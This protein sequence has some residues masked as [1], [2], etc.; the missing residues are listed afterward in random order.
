MQPLLYTFHD[1]VVHMC[2]FKCIVRF[3]VMDSIGRILLFFTSF[4]L[5]FTPQWS[6]SHLENGI[7]S[8]TYDFWVGETVCVNT[9]LP[10]G[11]RL[12]SGWLL[13]LIQ[14]TTGKVWFLKRCFCVCHRLSFIYLMAMS[15][16]LNMFL[17][18]FFKC[19]LPVIVLCAEVVIS[20]CRVQRGPLTQ[21]IRLVTHSQ[22]FSWMR[23]L[24]PRS[25]LS[26]NGG[27]EQPRWGPLLH[28]CNWMLLA[29]IFTKNIT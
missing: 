19:L 16:W 26:K 28:S 17:P 5:L 12:R 13:V 27:T 2:H 21:R 7:Q 4:L 24:Q 25:R 9:P 6:T 10:V 22:A 29:E 14:F 15:H 1:Y 11:G 8:P 18:L 23:Y 20:L 3:S